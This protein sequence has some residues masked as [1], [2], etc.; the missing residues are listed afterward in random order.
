VI[1]LC[2]FFACEVKKLLIISDKTQV[3]AWM[4][5]KQFLLQFCESPTLHFHG[6]N[7]LNDLPQFLQATTGIIS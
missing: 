7:V 4:S 5:N 3:T 2:S 1:A 6:Q